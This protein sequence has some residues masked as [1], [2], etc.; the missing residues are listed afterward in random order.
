[1]TYFIGLD[2]GQLQDFSARAVVR[3]DDGPQAPRS[4]D[5]SQHLHVTGLHRWPLKTKYAT[6]VADT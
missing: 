4:G 2:L 5:P 3:V 1:M 6:I